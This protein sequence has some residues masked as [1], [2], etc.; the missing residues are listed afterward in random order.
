MLSKQCFV[1]LH[2]AQL[3]RKKAKKRK[4]EQL[5]LTIQSE[6]KLLHTDTSDLDNINNWKSATWFWN[7]S[8]NESAFE[9]DKER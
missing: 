9:S 7:I 3:T 5:L 6:N 1:Q 2:Y 4:I 8:T